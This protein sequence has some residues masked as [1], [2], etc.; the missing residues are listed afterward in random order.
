MNSL[1][2]FRTLGL[3]RTLG[4]SSAT[5]P[6]QDKDHRGPRP[7]AASGVASIVALSY[8]DD[9]PRGGAHCSA[10]GLEKKYLSSLVGTPLVLVRLKRGRDVS[11]EKDQRDAQSRDRRDGDFRDSGR[12]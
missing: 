1:P 8:H 7:H 3:V 11:R 5:R 12:V 6:A 9:R 2:T 4:Q 10:D